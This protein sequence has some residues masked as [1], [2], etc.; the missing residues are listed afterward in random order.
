MSNG[1]P[2]VRKAQAEAERLGHSITWDEIGDHL[3]HGH[4]ERCGM[5]LTAASPD[6]VTQVVGDASTTPCPKAGPNG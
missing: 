5:T 6:G 1:G 3:A 4:C 2:F